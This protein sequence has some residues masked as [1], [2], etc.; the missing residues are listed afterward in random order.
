MSFFVNGIIFYLLMVAAVVGLA[1]ALGHF[2][3][4]TDIGV[5]VGIFLLCGLA[6]SLVGNVLASVQ[7]LKNPA[8]RLPQRTFAVCVLAV[9]ALTLVYV[10]KDVFLVRHAMGD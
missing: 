10:V 6:W 9:A 7:A 4:L 1:F 5:P 2:G 8:S 3:I